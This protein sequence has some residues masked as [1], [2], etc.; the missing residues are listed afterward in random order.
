MPYVMVP[1]P[2]EHVQEVMQ[3]I[4][5]AAARA[6]LEPWDEDSITELFHGVD[7]LSRS[8]L[9]FVARAVLAGQ[10]LS[11]ADAARKIQLSVRETLAIQR[12]LNELAKA[13]DRPALINQRT[14]TESLPSGRSTTTRV[15]SMEEEVA[16]LVSAAER[17]E[18]LGDGAASGPVAGGSA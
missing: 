2:E 8:L 15:L 3:L 7:E 17:H 18:L 4:L 13:E 5:S 1:V 14:I 16:K 11:E 9:S 10:E 12:E 6:A